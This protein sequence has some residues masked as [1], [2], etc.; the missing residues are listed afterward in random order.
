MFQSVESKDQCTEIKY[1]TSGGIK[2][3]GSTD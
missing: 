3:H 1:P 2:I